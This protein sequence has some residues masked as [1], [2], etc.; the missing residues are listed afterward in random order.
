M[1]FFR[2]QR[3]E[4]GQSI[5]VLITGDFFRKFLHFEHFELFSK[6]PFLLL[7][8]NTCRCL[9]VL[10][11]RREN[12]STQR[13]PSQKSPP[14]SCLRKI[15]KRS[16]IGKLINIGNLSNI[17]NINFLYCLYTLTTINKQNGK[18]HYFLFRLNI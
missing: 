14:T 6:L 7:A 4:I 2:I 16:N 12:S 3:T 17:D 10:Y 9:K 5:I 11:H 18:G 13:R 8:W 15:D 1:R